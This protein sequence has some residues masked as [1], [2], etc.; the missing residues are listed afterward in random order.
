MREI[1]ILSGRR[2]RH[3]PVLGR[4]ARARHRRVPLGRVRHAALPER[5]HLRAARGKRGMVRDEQL[6]LSFMTS[7]KFSGVWTLSL[8]VI[9]TL[10]QTTSTIVRFVAYLHSADVINGSNLSASSLKLK[11][12]QDPFV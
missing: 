6:R 12:L 9:I 5:R 8:L 1:Q 7:T 4:G 11:L 2:S 3:P 10:M